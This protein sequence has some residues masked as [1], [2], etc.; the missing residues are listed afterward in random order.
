MEVVSSERDV[1][2]REKEGRGERCGEGGREK[3]AKGESSFA[4][5]ES[6]RKRA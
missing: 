5:K 1:G 3:A 2:G 4:K 6:G